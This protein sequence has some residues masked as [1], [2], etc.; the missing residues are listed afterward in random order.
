MYSLSTSTFATLEILTFVT[1]ASSLFLVSLD[2]K[3]IWKDAYR[4]I[5]VISNRAGGHSKLSSCSCFT[6]CRFFVDQSDEAGG[7]A[8]G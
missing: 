7:E 1:G 3:D 2:R 6:I 5:I 8:V 4:S